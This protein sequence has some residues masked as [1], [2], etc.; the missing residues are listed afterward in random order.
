MLMLLRYQLIKVDA[1]NDFSHQHLSKTQRNNI[2]K[3][4]VIIPTCSFFIAIEV[5]Q[6]FLPLKS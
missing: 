3:E 4:Q 1:I 5:I 6:I 2:K